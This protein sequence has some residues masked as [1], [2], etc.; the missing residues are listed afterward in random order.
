M[1]ALVF[2]FISL[3]VFI[4]LAGISYA[5][6]KRVYGRRLREL[7]NRFRSLEKSYEE[8]HQSLETERARSTELEVRVAELE[9]LLRE[10]DGLVRT[11]A[12]H[13]RRMEPLDVLRAKHLVMDSDIQSAKDQLMATG[14]L[15]SLEE[16]LKGRKVISQEQLDE[17]VETAGKINSILAGGI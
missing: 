3:A 7:E 6:I 4:L 10:R 1:S 12:P 11:L 5:Q 2:F 8:T 9:A 13:K 16:V 15:K 17:A 14:E